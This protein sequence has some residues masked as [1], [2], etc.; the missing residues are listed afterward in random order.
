MADAETRYSRME[1]TAL[2]LRTAAQKLLP[3]F[4]AH[5]M[6]VLTDQPFRSVLHKPNISGMMLQWT[7]ELSEYEIEY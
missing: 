1:Q 5:P 3:D 2:A 7:I 6:T 4:Q